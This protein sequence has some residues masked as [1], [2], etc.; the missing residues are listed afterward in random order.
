MDKLDKNILKALQSNARISNAELARQIG[1]SASATAERVAKLERE[2]IICGYN[3]VVNASRVGLD[4]TAFI[5]VPVGTMDIGEMG[6][7]IAAV[8]QV[9]E[10]HKVTGNTCYLVKVRAENMAALEGIIDDINQVAPNTYSYVVLSTVKETVQL[11]LS[12]EGD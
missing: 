2:G 12:K 1:L 3:A 7:R 6:Q 9:L 10:C 11:D 4:V 5:L 8:S